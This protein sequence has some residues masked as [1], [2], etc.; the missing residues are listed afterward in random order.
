MSY[1]DYHSRFDGEGSQAKVLVIEDN[2]DI[3]ILFYETLQ[4]KGFQVFLASD[5]KIGMWMAEELMPDLILSDIDL[6][7]LDGYEILQRL[8]QNPDTANIPFVF[9]SGKESDDSYR[10]GIQLGAKAYLI[11]PVDIHVLV[12]TVNTHLLPQRFSPR[13]WVSPPI[14]SEQ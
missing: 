9:C 8:R 11:K 12:E 3:Q 4:A 13:Y 6:P 14:T 5:G 2:P 1:L 7:E 10:R